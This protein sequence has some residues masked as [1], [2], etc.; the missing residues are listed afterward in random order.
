LNIA[1]RVNFATGKATILKQSF[2]ILDNLVALLNEYK[3]AKIVVEGHTDN[4]GN[5][6]ANKK[7]SQQRADAIKAYVVKK[8]ISADR[9]QA[10]GYGDE[11]PADGSTDIKAGNKTPQQRAANRR[12]EIKNID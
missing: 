7:L 9:I 4:V 3:D 11:R 5:K 6:A 10:I 12:V 1:K 8:G 2:P